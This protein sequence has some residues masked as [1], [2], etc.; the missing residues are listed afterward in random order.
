MTEKQLSILNAALRLFAQQGFSA[1]PTSQI[2]KE[3]GVSEGLIFRHFGK[4]DGLL[5]A[6]IN[7]GEESF[8]AIFADIAMASTP[9]E[10]L[11]K[12]ISMPF[13][14][15]ESDYEFWRLQFKL[16]WELE[17]FSDSKLVP[18][19]LVLTN[20]FEK[21]NYEEAALEAETLMHLLEG[22]SSAMLKSKMSRKKELHQFL[23]K[24]YNL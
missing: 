5:K 17:S 24:K 3:A 21:L 6:V 19:R 12:A 4:K 18:M 14:V 10:L 8:K 9:K 16:K 2:A 23:L 1:T 22:I 7:E 15:P 20:A 13:D 11:R